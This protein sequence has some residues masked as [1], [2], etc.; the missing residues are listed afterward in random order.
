LTLIVE[1]KSRQRLRNSRDDWWILGDD[2]QLAAHPYYKAGRPGGCEINCEEAVVTYSTR[3]PPR[4]IERLSSFNLSCVT[5]FDPCTALE[6]L[7][8][9]ARDWNLYKDEDVSR[10]KVEDAEGRP[11]AVPLWAIARDSRYVL[12]V[13]TISAK[14][15]DQPGAVLSSSSGEY[16]KGPDFRVE[17]A[18]VKIE[19]ILKGNPPWPRLSI[20]AARPYAGIITDLGP[21]QEAAEH[22]SPGKSYIV[23]PIGDDRRDQALGAASPISLNQCGVWND[24]PENRSEL[25]KGF[26]ENDSLREPELR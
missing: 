2:S 21:S 25:E 23:F 11:C 7:L 8:P 9:A 5:R 17:E 15:Q 22:L 12:A 14:M 3:T 4:E 6:Q 16:E 18:R 19:E 1:S 26:A 24:T 20:M 13:E 10:R